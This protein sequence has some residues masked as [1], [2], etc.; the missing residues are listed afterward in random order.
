[1]SLSSNSLALGNTQGDLFQAQEG[2][3]TKE[4][5]VFKSA[6]T[7]KLMSPFL[8]LIKLTI[9]NYKDWCATEDTNFIIMLLAECE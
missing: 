1:M 2:F 9:L 4:G 5:S 6:A 8:A 3:Y 7:A